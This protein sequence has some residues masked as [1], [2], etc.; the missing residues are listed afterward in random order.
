MHVFDTAT[1]QVDP[2]NAPIILPGVS[3]MLSSGDYVG[4]A[5]LG[6]YNDSATYYVPPD[7]P[8]AT[9][10]C[11]VIN[12]QGTNTVQFRYLPSAQQAAIL[13]QSITVPQQT[14]KTLQQTVEKT[15][16]KQKNSA[17]KNTQRNWLIYIFYTLLMLGL[18]AIGVTVWRTDMV[19]GN[20]V[21]NDLFS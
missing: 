12:N 9:S 10:C 21:A 19:L 8:A 4:D 7:A 14:V 1:N 2:A 11:T 5:V 17:I 15:I 3:L 18:G 13:P 6:A 16:E 20:T